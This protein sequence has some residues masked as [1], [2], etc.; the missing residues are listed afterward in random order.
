MKNHFFII[1][2][3]GYRW[4][5]SNQFCSKL[6]QM[7]KILQHS[8]SA[9]LAGVIFFWASINHGDIYLEVKIPHSLWMVPFCKFHVCFFDFF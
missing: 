3:R 7:P 1:L 8:F 6:G 4:V 2:R 5:N 9:C